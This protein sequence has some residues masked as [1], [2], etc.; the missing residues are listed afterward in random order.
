M[1]MVLV[2]LDVSGS[3][4]AFVFKQSYHFILMHYKSLSSIADR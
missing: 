4:K 3:I 1:I 2:L